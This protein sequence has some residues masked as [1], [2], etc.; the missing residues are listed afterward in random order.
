MPSVVMNGL[1]PTSVM[2][3]PL[4]KPT[5]VP[6][7][8]PAPIATGT[9][10][11]RDANTALTRPESASVDPTERSNAPATSSTVMPTAMMLWSDTDSS[12]AEMLGRLRNSG[13]A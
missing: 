10:N 3:R 8:R 13:A 2:I 7:P 1:M 6:T 11:P 12:T 5:S 4:T 9:G